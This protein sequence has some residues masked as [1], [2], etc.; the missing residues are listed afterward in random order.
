MPGWANMAAVPSILGGNW[1]VVVTG[2]RWDDEKVELMA[3]QL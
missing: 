1:G 3:R 2:W